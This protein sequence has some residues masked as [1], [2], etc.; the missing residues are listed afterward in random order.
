MHTHI[1]F[2]HDTQLFV[3]FTSDSEDIDIVDVLDQLIVQEVVSH[4]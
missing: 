3:K 1:I 2:N 4:A